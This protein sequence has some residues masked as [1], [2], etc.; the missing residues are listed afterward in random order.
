MDTPGQITDNKIQAIIPQELKLVPIAI[1][2]QEMEALRE[3]SPTQS[4][5]LNSSKE[6]STSNFKRVR[7]RRKTAKM[8]MK[9]TSLKMKRKARMKTKKL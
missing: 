4:L 1:T 9:N 7:P 2:A 8:T 6:K 3:P 5:L